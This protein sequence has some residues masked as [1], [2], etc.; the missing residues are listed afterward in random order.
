VG[1][2]GPR[3]HRG[4]LGPQG[5]IGPSG[6]RGKTG[7]QGDEGSAAVLAEVNRHI[8]DIYKELDVQMKRI[9]QMQVQIDE[10]RKKLTLA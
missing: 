6:A 1:A 4:A 5:A 9:G 10:I 3:G 2:R 7:H 8:E